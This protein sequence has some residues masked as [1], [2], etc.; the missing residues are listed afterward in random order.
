[1]LG[2]KR[3]IV[4]YIQNQAHFMYGSTPLRVEANFDVTRPWPDDIYGMKLCEGRTLASP[5]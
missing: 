4:E 1:M 5:T 2:W 3:W